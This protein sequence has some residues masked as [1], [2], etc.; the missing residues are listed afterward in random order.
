MNPDSESQNASEI[1]PSE[2][3]ETSSG[4]GD[5]I[6]EEGVEIVDVEI[7]D[8]EVV[9][10]PL[11]WETPFTSSPFSTTREPSNHPGMGGNSPFAA[12]VTPEKPDALIPDRFTES[13]TARGA[14]TAA[15]GLGILGLIASF[16]TGWGMVPCLLGV[17]MSFWGT[18]SSFRQRAVV[19]L[20][21]SLGAIVLC[22]CMSFVRPL[23]ATRNPETHFSGLHTPSSIWIP[24]PPRR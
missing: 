23:S 1:T 15:V 5:D 18:T 19:G 22:L 14:A 6:L 12:E 21:L 2:P 9:S 8:A 4:K 24:L 3:E 20:A 11:I 13:Y 10:E 17:T 16:F 7:I